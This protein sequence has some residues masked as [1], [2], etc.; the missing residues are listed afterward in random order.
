MVWILFMDKGFL[1]L[2]EFQHLLKLLFRTSSKLYF[3]SCHCMH[4]ARMGRDPSSLLAQLEVLSVPTTL[5]HL[6]GVL[7]DS[8]SSYASR[9]WHFSGSWAIRSWLIS[10]YHGNRYTVVL[11]KNPWPIWNSAKKCQTL[12]LEKTFI[13][14]R[15]YYMKNMVY[16]K[17]NLLF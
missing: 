14:H 16:G 8:N 12:D 6:V 1:T 4:P 2:P 7:L 11:C 5:L 10:C 13:H 17:I 15:A 3:K 9:S